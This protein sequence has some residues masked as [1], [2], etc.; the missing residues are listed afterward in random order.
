MLTNIRYILITAWR[1]RMFWVLLAGVLAAALI[2]HVLGATAP[3]N[4]GVLTLSYSSNAARI[5][6]IIGLVIFTC[7]HLHN[8]FESHEVDVF[9]SR[10]ITRTNLVISYW[11]GFAAVAFI[12]AAALIALMALQGVMDWTGFF[13]WSLSLLAECWLAVAIALFA[14]FTLRKSATSVLA[15]MGFYMLGRMIG[16]FLITI[17]SAFLFEQQWLNV[18]LTGTLKY[19]SVIIPRL[20]FF[21]KDDWLVHG[22]K[23]MQDVE[24][25]ALQTLVFIPLLILA[26]IADFRRKQF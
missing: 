26:T 9:L 7:S 10:P 21:A 15:S 5:M 2:A 13:W 1:D 20:D 25:F 14:S 24:L 11:L 4:T 22:V 23:H 19:I 8:A 12:H 17:K 3:A 18:I 6:I 16:Y